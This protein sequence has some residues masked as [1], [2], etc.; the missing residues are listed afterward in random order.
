MTVESRNKKKEEKG[1]R[2]PDQSPLESLQLHVFM[3]VTMQCE[4]LVM[5]SR[6]TDATLFDEVTAVEHE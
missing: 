3:V 4:E 6:F 1:E 2:G 5:R